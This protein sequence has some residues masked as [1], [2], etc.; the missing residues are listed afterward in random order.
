MLKVVTKVTPWDGG[1]VA[2]N[3]FG[4]GGANG[5]CIMKSYTKQKKGPQNLEEDLP[6]L[7][8][9]SARNESAITFMIN[10]VLI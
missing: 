1:I 4:V 9:V 6:R 7:V 10:R 5:H 3:S 8:V 2:V